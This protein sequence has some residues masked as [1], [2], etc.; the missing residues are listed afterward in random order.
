M[1]CRHRED[2]RRKGAAQRRRRLDNPKPLPELTPADAGWLAGIIDGEGSIV[3]SYGGSRSPHLRVQI[4]NGSPAIL[5]K[6]AA[7]LASADVTATSFREKR[8][9]TNLAVGTEGALVLHALTRPYL[10]RQVEQYDAAV[11]FMRNRYA[12]G[13]LRVLW[14]ETDRQEW[15]DLRAQFHPGRTT[16]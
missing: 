13:R 8:G 11:T 15:A 14:T 5:D 3:L 6:I 16:V 7:V 10:V 2:S 9:T 4:T 1:R 12:D